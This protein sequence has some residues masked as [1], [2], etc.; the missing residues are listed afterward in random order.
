M[1]LLTKAITQKFA[2]VGDQSA[3]KDPIIVCKFFDPCSSRTW[4]AAEYYPEDRICF[5]YVVGHFP[6]W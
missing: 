5:G 1:K 2:K 4:Y 6:E 3:E